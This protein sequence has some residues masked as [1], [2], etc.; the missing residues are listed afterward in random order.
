LG[1]RSSNANFCEPCAFRSPDL[2]LRDRTGIIFL[3]YRLAELGVDRP[4]LAFSEVLSF[5]LNGESIH[6]VHQKAGYSDADALTHFHVANLFYL[7]EAFPGDGY[8]RI[9]A[10]QGGTLE[11]L[12]DE[13]TWTNNEQRIVPARGKVTNGTTLKA[14]RDMIVTVRDRVQRMIH[15]GRT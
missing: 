10:D 13:L 3:L 8:R 7:G 1:Y 6:I 2:G 11:G 4:R 5:D 12:L 15:E 14:F 9:D